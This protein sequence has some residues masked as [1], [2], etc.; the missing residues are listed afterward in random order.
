[1]RFL[2]SGSGAY[3]K[4]ILVALGFL[5]A[6]TLQ[7]LGAENALKDYVSRP[8]P[9]YAWKKADTSTTDGFI[10]TRLELVSQDWR[11]NPWTHQLLVVRPP[12]VRNKDI[13]LLFITGDGDVKKQFETLR[14][15]ATRAGAI[16]AIVNRIPNQP[17]FDGKEED[18][19]IAYTFDQF[20][21]TGDKTWPALFPMVKSAVRAMDAV[22]AFARE[23]HHQE[24]QRF[25]VTGAS[26]R[27]WTS[28]LTA[29]VDP[30]VKAAAPMVIDM[31]NM[32]AQ[33][34]WAKQVYGK[35]SEEIQ[36]YTDHNLLDRMD[37]PRMVELRGWVDPYSYRSD[38]TLP[39]LLLLG[40]ND[41]YWVV[42]SLRHYWSDLPG[43]K[44]VFQTPNA[45]HD[46][47]EGRDAIP[48]LAAFYQMI[49]DHQSW[50]TFSWKFTSALPNA[51][52]IEL[53]T[54]QAPKSVRLWTANSKGRDFRGETWS[55]VEMAGPAKRMT[56]NVET[57]KE[58]FRAYML[59]AEFAGI[60]GK[61]FK[62]STE[63]R[64][65][66]DGPPKK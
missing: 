45:G 57:P 4:L 59:E 19:L 22:Q 61:T 21:Q 26:K 3:G 66:P 37:D 43:P 44:Y 39:K 18:A 38:Y 7:S 64:V 49:A 50:P 62:L 31:L 47:A 11:G 34:A 1:M 36:D 8:D 54:T 58:G 25:L 27:G 16:A 20:L 28:W 6:I 51:A 23:E 9:T 48:V 13:A 32:K 42:D 14:T 46:L 17:L 12:E 35:Q 63:A 10:A 55:S 52:T 56:A 65:T 29:A 30:R 40:T 24:I 33:M 53:D 15:L 41:P 5:G 2:K 60:D